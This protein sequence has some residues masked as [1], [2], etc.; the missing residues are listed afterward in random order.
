MSA[1]EK[2]VRPVTSQALRQAV[3]EQ[4]SKLIN[5]LGAVQC[6]KV[7]IA[8]DTHRE[9]TVELQGAVEL[10]EDEVQR[11]VTALDERSLLQPIEA[12]TEAEVCA[13]GRFTDGDPERTPFPGLPPALPC[14]FCGHHDDIMISEEDAPLSQGGK[15]YRVNCGHCGVDAPGGDTL[16][17]AATEWN[18]RPGKEAP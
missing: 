4:R 9:I 17:K 18:T 6:M 11:I 1:T 12:S 3:E 16:L 5:V 8:H 2:V 15:W 14:P 7:A 13:V 10:L